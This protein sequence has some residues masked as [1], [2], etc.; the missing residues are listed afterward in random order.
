[1]DTSSLIGLKASLAI[2]FVR[3]RMSSLIERGKLVSPDEVRREILEGEDE[4]VAWAR[5][6]GRGMFLKPTARDFDHLRSLLHVCPRAV[7]LLRPKRLWADG[8]VVALAL[9][10]KHETIESLFPEVQLDHV[11]VVSQ[12]L[13]ARGPTREDQSVRIPDLCSAKGINCIKLDTFLEVEM[14]N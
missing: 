2:P 10:L 1:M 9:R 13:P 14:S 7:P 3:S 6:D 11:R 8:Y 12:E 5:G 4:L